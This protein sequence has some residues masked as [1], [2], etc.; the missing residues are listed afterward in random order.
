MKNAALLFC[1]LLY[2]ASERVLRCDA[3]NLSKNDFRIKYDAF[4]LHQTLFADLI[5]RLLFRLQTL[6]SFVGEF[7]QRF[8]IAQSSIFRFRFYFASERVLRGGAYNL[9]RNDFKR[10]YDAFPLHQTL[11]AIK[12]LCRLPQSRIS[13]AD[14]LADAQT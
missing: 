12:R 11:F 13:K 4:L 9:S 2:F 14:F 10:K 3:Y 7:W 6:I 1:F 5:F 8:L